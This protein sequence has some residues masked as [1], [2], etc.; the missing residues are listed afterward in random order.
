MESAQPAQDK[1]AELVK[2]SEKE[3]LAFLQSIG[4]L[5]D[6]QTLT[7]ISAEHRRLIL[8]KPDDFMKKVR[9]SGKKKSAAEELE[10]VVSE[11]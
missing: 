9:G 7:N 1:L 10:S 11:E 8:S 4:W 5:E 2:G 3:A 6:G